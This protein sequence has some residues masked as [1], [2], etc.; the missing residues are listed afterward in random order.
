MRYASNKG[1]DRSHTHFI[2]APFFLFFSFFFFFF[3][4]STGFHADLNNTVVS[5][6]PHYEQKKYNKCIVIFATRIQE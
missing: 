3:F 6:L 1:T 2:L 4:T 5:K